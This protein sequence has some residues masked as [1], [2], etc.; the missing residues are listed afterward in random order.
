MNNSPTSLTC[1]DPALAILGDKWSPLILK[2]L[3][4]QPECRFCGFEEA[5]PG[6]SP[7]TLAARLKKM[8]IAGIITKQ[9]LAS[10]RHAYELTPKGV[11]LLDVITAMGT[12]SQKYA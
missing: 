6:I 1:I 5:L 8:E 10:G 3:A 11:D 9:P 7:R 4:E 12:W 2:T